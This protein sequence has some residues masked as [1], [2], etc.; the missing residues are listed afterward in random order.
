MDAETIGQAFVLLGS[1]RQR[2]EDTV[3]STVGFSAIKKIG[4]RVKKGESLL[5]VHARN[6]QTLLSVLPLLEQAIEIARGADLDS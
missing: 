1:G 2:V 6:E 5:L 3:D 4:E